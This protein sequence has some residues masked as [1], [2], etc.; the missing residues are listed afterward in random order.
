V[1]DV[2][3]YTI[4]VENTGNVTVSDIDV[5]DDLTGDTWFIASLD[6]GA[7]ETFI[8]TY[9]ITQA[10]LDN[11]SVTNIV[12]AEGE[13]TNG[14]PVMDSDSVTITAVQD[15]EITVTKSA[16]PITYSLVGE[17]ITYTI[18]VT[19]TGNV[20]VSDID[21]VDDLTGDSWNIV[22]LAPGAVETFIAT[23]VI[24]QADLD[25]SSV[26]NT[27][28]A[29]GEDT[30]GD[31][32]TDSDS[33]TVT[34]I[35]NP[36]IT[37]TKTADPTTYDTVGD[38]ITYTIS[39]EN[40][41]NVTVSDID[42]VDDLTGDTWFIASLDPGAVE[43]FIAT[44]VITQAD[45][46]NGSVTNTVTAEGEDTNGDPVMDSDSE[47][48][49]AIQNPEIT[50]T[51]TADQT[52]YDTLGDIIEY[53][54]T[55]TNTGN[56]TVS[57]IDIVDDLTGDSWNIVTLAPGAVETFIA[58]Y[59][60]TQADLDNGSVT[61]TVTTE[62]EDTNGDSVTDSGS[63]TVTAVQ[64]PELTITKTADRETYSNEDEVIEYTLE[65]TNTGN[66][67]LYDVTV[68]DPL[69]GFTQLINILSPGES[70]AFTTTYTVTYAD[71]IAGSITNTATAST[72]Y[73][74]TDVISSD[75]EIVLYDLLDPVIN[76]T[77]VNSDV[78]CFGEETGTA[79][80]II[81][82]GLQPYNII[83]YTDPV[84]TGPMAFDIPAGTYVVMVTD[85]LGNSA[86]ETF[87]INQPLE[88]L[89]IMEYITHAG[90][91]GEQTGF[92]EIEVF[93]GTQPYTFSW[94]NGETTQNI[95]NLT[96]GMYSLL[97]EDVNG[98]DLVTEFEM[99]EPDA[100]FI[101][102]IEITGT[103]CITDE[104]GIITF[105]TNGGV[106]PY[107]YLWSNG[108]TEPHLIN[109]VSGDYS[110]EITDSNGC[111]L[112]YDFYIPFETDECEIT[113][114]QGF[115]PNGDGFNDL[116]VI[117]G[118]TAYPQNKVQVFNRWGTLVYEAS[119][120]EN[121]WDAVPNRGRIFDSA[122]KLP[123]GTYYY[124]ITLEPGGEII[125]GW[126]YIAR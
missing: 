40:T 71:L 19:N 20:T 17:V 111:T 107:S 101:S 124:L 81:S 9:V 61:N 58:T 75:S 53:T 22:T 28:N 49:T 31:P 118:I 48:V 52:T 84:Q 121:D 29:E 2:I 57:D 44:Y 105:D 39:V 108:S 24:T 12:T 10:D 26:T 92:I 16:D 91:H 70:A 79:E 119:P 4:S 95:Y 102:N 37:V 98:C 74:G 68:E 38:V 106:P 15:A 82:G 73:N 33:A 42:I 65:V 54:I 83:W 55:V 6:P 35:Q 88:P 77:I 62:G 11:G 117:D 8:A 46:D 36:E 78:L 5:V 72:N 14:D 43:T 85:T 32:V 45:L 69:T 47:T 112:N 27:V 76:I 114:S 50:V 125:T 104:T 123:A 3:T 87:T 25:N 67:T 13:D 34:A 94:S 122:G 89:N 103:T 60:I 64:S 59:V 18:T 51:K 110:V 93:G 63:A 66:V 90:C 1:G 100:L 99:T 86:Q 41:G 30:I 7:V 21:V 115:S 23:Y 126:V 109:A 113:A 80:A 97:I 120:Y 56:V 116:W 96:A